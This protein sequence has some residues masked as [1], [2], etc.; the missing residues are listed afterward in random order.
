MTN[1]VRKMLTDAVAQG[2]TL[3]AAYD[4]EID[5]RGAD[6]AQAEDA[7]NACD[8]MSVTIRDAENKPVGWA[9]VVNGLAEDERIADTSAWVDD[10]W[11]VNI[12]VGL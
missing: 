7:I 3:E 5:Y 12:G 9:L 10:W 1:Y 6:V 8:E 11:N 4:G 2:Y